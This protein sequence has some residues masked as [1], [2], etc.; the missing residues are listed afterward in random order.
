ME[1]MPHKKSVVFYV[2]L[3]TIWSIRDFV[4]NWKFITNVIWSHGSTIVN[5]WLYFSW[6]TTH[7][8]TGTIWLVNCSTSHENASKCS[9]ICHVMI[10]IMNSF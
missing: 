4:C 9:I 6:Y 1:N 7:K 10:W 8:A 5:T 2:Q 3:H